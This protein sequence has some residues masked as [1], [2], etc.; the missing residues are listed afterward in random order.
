MLQALKE[1]GIRAVVHHGGNTTNGIGLLY[2]VC[3]KI[4]HAP[5]FVI[6]KEQN[7]M[8]VI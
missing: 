7:I 8:Y 3:V 6:D 2:G 5:Y 1:T 4:V